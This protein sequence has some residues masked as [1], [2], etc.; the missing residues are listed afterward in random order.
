MLVGVGDVFGVRRPDGIVEKAGIWA[1]VDDRGR[2]EAGLLVQE[3]LVL[4]GGVRKVSD[5]FA[6]GTP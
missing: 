2:L 5:G 1:E 6:V 3:E 4:A